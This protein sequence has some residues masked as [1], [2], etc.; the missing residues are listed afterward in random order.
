MRY[1][2][3]RWNDGFLEIVNKPN[4]KPNKLGVDQGT[5]FYNSLIQKWLDDKCW[6]YST[7]NEGKSIVAERFIKILPK[8]FIDK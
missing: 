4:H 3:D 1:P 8:K 6:M 2:F 5:G 7:H